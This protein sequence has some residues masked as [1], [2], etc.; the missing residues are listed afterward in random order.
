MVVLGFNSTFTAKVISWLSV[1]HASFL[2]F[3]TS[4]NT[5][6]FPK[7]PTTFLTGFCRGKRRK[8]AGKK[9]CL[10]QVSNSQ[11][12]VHESDRLTIEP[13]GQGENKTKKV[14]EN[15]L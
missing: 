11:T 5:T 6:V 8:Y 13:P 9:L 15:D 14:L 1:T 4:T 10:N 2:A 3:S 12:A 7:P